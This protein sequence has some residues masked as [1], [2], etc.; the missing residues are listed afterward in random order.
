MW[1]FPDVRSPALR[2][3]QAVKT[4]I[5]LN[6]P[7]T[8]NSRPN[9]ALRLAGRLADRQGAEVRA[10][11]LGEGVLCAVSGRYLPG[12]DPYFESLLGRLLGKVEVAYSEVCA[13]E[14]GLDSKQVVDGIRCSNL[15]ELANWMLWS[16]N[17]LVF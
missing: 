14:R 2:N 7:P 8:R 5:L 16:E 9:D 11:F 3:G 17:T 1:R 12:A 4:L 15:D 13:D 10:F 6:E